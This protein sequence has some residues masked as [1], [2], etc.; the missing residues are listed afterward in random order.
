MPAEVAVLETMAQAAQAAQVVA[1]QR[2]MRE[3]KAWLEQQTRVV[4]EEVVVIPLPSPVGRA[5]Q[6]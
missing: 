3:R 6:A 2:E 4:G 5:A 1:G